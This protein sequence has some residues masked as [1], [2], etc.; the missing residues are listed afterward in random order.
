VGSTVFNVPTDRPDN[1]LTI[2]VEN[3]AAVELSATSARFSIQN[4]DTIALAVDRQTPANGATGI[5]PNAF[6][7][8][9]FNKPI[10]PALLTIFGARN[11]PRPNLCRF[12][13]GR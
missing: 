11:R 6:I 10:D 8:L 13:P 2:R 9:Y 4:M 5:E 3:S 7:A 1:I 12:A